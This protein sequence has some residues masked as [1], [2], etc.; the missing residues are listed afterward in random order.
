[1]MNTL[2]AETAMNSTKALREFAETIYANL[3]PIVKWDKERDVQGIMDMVTALISEHYVEREKYD[4]AI[5]AI[6]IL[7][8]TIKQF[9]KENER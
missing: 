9:T 2:K 1:L 5:E 7:N 8:E 6:K 4:T 3:L